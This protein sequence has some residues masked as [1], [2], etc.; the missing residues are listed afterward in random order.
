MIKAIKPIGYSKKKG[1]IR[2]NAINDYIGIH[3]TKGVKG[4]LFQIIDEGIGIKEEDLTH[5]FERFYRSDE[6]KEIPGTGLGLTIAKE[7]IELHNG[8]IDVESEYGKG[9]T[10]S[11]FLP[12]LEKNI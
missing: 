2:I 1:L 11:V 8:E 5:L 7:L 4:T 12:T 10:F 3:N 9:S 6:V